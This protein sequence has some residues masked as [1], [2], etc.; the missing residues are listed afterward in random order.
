MNIFCKIIHKLPS[1][2]MIF[3]LYYIYHVFIQGFNNFLP[4]QV[5]YEA[6]YSGIEMKI[7]GLALLKDMAGS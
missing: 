1:I 2:N 3:I 4:I 6:K 5:Y 7:P